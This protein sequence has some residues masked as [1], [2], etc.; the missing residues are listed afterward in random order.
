MRKIISVVKYGVVLASCMC[1][2]GAQQVNADYTKTDIPQ[3]FIETAAEGEEP[4]VITKEYTAATITVVDKEGG[5]F[6]DFQDTDAQVKLHGNSTS[7]AEKKPY[8]IKLSSKEE[9]LGMDAGK[10]WTILANAFDKTLLRNKLGFDLAQKMGMAYTSDTTFVDVWVDGVFMGNYLIAEPVEAGSTKVDIDVDKGDFMLEIERERDEE[11]VTY[12]YTSK[13]R[14]RYAINEPEEPTNEQVKAINDF[15]T[16]MENALATHKLSQYEKYMDVDSFVDYYLIS[17]L[18]KA[19]DINYSSTRFYCKDG[20]MYAGPL[21]DIDLSS[22]NA[23]KQF[24][25]G[26]YREGDGTKGLFAAEVKW[27]NELLK[28]DEFVEKLKKRYNEIFPMVENLY[29]TNSLGTNRI[30][31]LVNAMSASIERNYS[32]EEGGAGWSMTYRYSVGDNALGLEGEA[33]DTYEE[34]VEVLR[35][36]LKG[37]AEYLK[38]KWG[39]ITK[40]NKVTSVTATQKSYKSFTVTWKTGGDADGVELYVNG[41]KGT[42]LYNTYS[43]T[44]TSVVVKNL[45]PKKKYGFSVRSFVTSADGTKYYSDYKTCDKQKLKLK[46]PKVKQKITKKNKLK[47]KW[48]KIKGA[49]G[50]K[51]YVAKVK[52]GSS[53]I[54]YK[55]VKKIKKP[56]ITT[57]TYK[58]KLKK[59]YSYYVKVVAY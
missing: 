49:K 36:W 30:D 19:V 20:I 58:K 21:W 12:I 32:S 7:K 1:I 43:A 22:G 27:F 48:K 56:T 17:E 9:L 8:K 57:Y 50:Y 52:K 6:E 34:N 39:E 38:T 11:D 14:V 13:Y 37:R 16:K 29:K 46:Q 42:Y 31:A 24:Y 33:K 28:S 5:V 4:Q 55:L 25:A 59:K 15:T 54:K 23:S 3:I 45:T 2:F 40:K 41:P 47:L 35:A 26:Y 44:T 10:K 51:V 18:F 53:K